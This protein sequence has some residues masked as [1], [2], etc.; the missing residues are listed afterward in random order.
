MQ[1]GLYTR[2]GKHL[3]GQIGDLVLSWDRHQGAKLGASLNVTGESIAL[4]SFSF[5]AQL[6][7]DDIEA[8]GQQALEAGALH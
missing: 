7:D 3:V 5:G 4:G 8:L 2:Q 6:A 1:I